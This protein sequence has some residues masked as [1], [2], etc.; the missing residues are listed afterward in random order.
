MA[1]TRQSPFDQKHTLMTKR[2]ARSGHRPGSRPRCTI[3]LMGKTE[4][5]QVKKWIWIP[6]QVLTGMKIKI[7][8]IPVI[9]IENRR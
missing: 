5:G 6:A 4:R 2:G 7:R 9:G 3:V 8:L 1:E